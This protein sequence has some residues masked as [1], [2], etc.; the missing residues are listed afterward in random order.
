M[1]PCGGSLY[2]GPKCAGTTPLNGARH[3]YF[4]EAV[5]Q[6]ALLRSRKVY[7][8]IGRRKQVLRLL[9]PIPYRIPGPRKKGYRDPAYLLT[10]ELRGLAANSSERMRT[11]GK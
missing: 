1:L 3:G 9:A 7:W 11:A 2:T 10:T 5:A 4:P 8:Q 6:D